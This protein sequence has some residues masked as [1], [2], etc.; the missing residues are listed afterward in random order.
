MWRTDDTR[1]RRPA[2]RE[3]L[4]SPPATPAA[5]RE[6]GV[7]GTGAHRAR[8]GR[9]SARGRGL[10]QVRVVR[11]VEEHDVE[12]RLGAVRRQPVERIRA[13]TTRAFS[14]PHS[15]ATASM[16]AAARRSFSTNV[17]CAAPRDSA[18]SPSAPLPANRSSTRAW[19]MRGCSQLNRVSRTRSGVGRISTPAG[20][21]SRRPRCRPPMMRRTRERA[22][23]FSCTTD[24]RHWRARRR[25]FF[26]C[27]LAFANVLSPWRLACH[28]LGPK[29]T[30]P[31]QYDKFGASFCTARECDRLTSRKQNSEERTHEE[32]ILQPL[33]WLSSLTAGCSSSVDNP[34]DVD[35]DRSDDGQPRSACHRARCRPTARLFSPNQGILPYPHDAYFTPT[36]GVPP[37]AR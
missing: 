33:P 22:P 8:A 28:L 26:R 12:G 34:P 18:S 29:R 20:N 6:R 4:S 14:S 30:L 24:L 32:A 15:R 10:E 9:A 27:F 16:A 5:D 19:S 1:P 13:Q 36:P 35:A 31:P 23:A 25:D 17:T 11:R 7:R 21:R 2:P 37:T 3:A